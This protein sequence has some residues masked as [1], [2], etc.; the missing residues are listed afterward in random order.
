MKGWR[1]PTDQRMLYPEANLFSGG[2]ICWLR[3]RL[4]EGEKLKQS[5]DNKYFVLGDQR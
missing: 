2:A 4:V 1:D 5:L 3:L